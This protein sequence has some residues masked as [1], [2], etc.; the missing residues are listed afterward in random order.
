VASELIKRIVVLLVLAAAAGFYLAPR[1]ASVL[2]ANDPVKSDVILVLAGDADD[3][4]FWRGMS[5]MSGGYASHLILDVQAPVN[6]FGI[7]D[8]ELARVFVARNAPGRAVVCEVH[9]DSTF[10]EVSAAAPCLQTLHPASV[11]LVTSDYHTRRALT[12][13]RRLLPQYQWHVAAVGGPSDADT[14]WERTADQW[15]KNRRWA[16]TMLDEWQKWTWW[17]LVDRWRARPVS[18]N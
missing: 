18:T 9:G 12:I 13:F 4:R 5:L 14:P 6:R 8:T 3:S 7:S 17:F 10:E 16:K 11:L 1:A 15:W 2:V